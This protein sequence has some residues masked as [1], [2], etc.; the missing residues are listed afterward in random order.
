MRLLPGT[1]FSH[2]V[3]ICRFCDMKRGAFSEHSCFICGRFT[4]W[5]NDMQAA[6]VCHAHQLL[7]P[8]NL[9][10]CYL[11]RKP[12]FIDSAMVYLCALCENVA[13]KRCA[14][15]VTDWSGLN[16]KGWYTKGLHPSNAK[17]TAFKPFF[18]CL[19]DLAITKPYLPRTN[20]RIY[21]LMFFLLFCFYYAGIWLLA[22]FHRAS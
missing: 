21:I 8:P 18:L 4:P 1:A 14:M 15:L 9:V 7:G 3:H 10:M 20:W 19:G 16:Y 2:N 12:A 5:R 13:I 22:R 17:S 6:R 11:C